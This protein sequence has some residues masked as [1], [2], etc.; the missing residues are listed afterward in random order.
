[1]AF[2]RT[3]I[4]TEV[5]LIHQSLEAKITASGM[6]VQREQEENQ[7]GEQLCAS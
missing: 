6:T 1:M 4:L 5:P 7:R 3:S 2:S